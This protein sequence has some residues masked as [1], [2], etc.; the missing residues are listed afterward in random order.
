MSGTDRTVMPAGHLLDIVDDEWRADTLPEDGAL[1][2]RVATSDGTGI[3]R[4]S[5]TFP[6]D[7]LCPPRAHPRGPQTTFADIQ[8]PAGVAPP[9]DDTEEPTG[10]DPNAPEKWTELGL[11][12]VGR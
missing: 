7:S 11:Q 1:P 8:L 9:A 5:R 2:S 4:R 12:N 10:V 6:P 3:P